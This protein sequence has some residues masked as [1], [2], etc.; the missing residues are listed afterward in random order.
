MTI[1]DFAALLERQQVA[2]LKK[3]YP[4]YPADLVADET[5]VKV[6]PGRKYTKVDVGTS[7]KFMVDEAGNIFGIKGYGVIHRGHAYGTLKTTGEWNWSGYYPT[8][9]VQP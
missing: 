6:T 8:R 5:A 1:Q 7:G 2:Q 4:D 3:E 9:R